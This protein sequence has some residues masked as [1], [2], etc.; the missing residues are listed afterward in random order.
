MDGDIEHEPQRVAFIISVTKFFLSK[1]RIKL[2]MKKLYQAD[3]YAVRELLKITTMLYKA[4]ATSTSEISESRK[5]LFR[6][7]LEF[8]Y[9]TAE[10]EVG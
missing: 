2:N 3:G 8:K 9:E 5:S 10:F 6:T 4:Q 1:T 7:G